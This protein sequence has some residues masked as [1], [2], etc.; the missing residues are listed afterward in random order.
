MPV[1]MK[2]LQVVTLML[3]SDSYWNVCLLEFLLKQSYLTKKH[4]YLVLEKAIS[5]FVLANKI[6]KKC[7]SLEQIN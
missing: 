4:T 7:G 1:F 2:I 3:E 5:M 6:R